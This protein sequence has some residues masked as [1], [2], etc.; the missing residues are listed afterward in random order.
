M[1]KTSILFPLMTLVAFGAFARTSTLPYELI[2]HDPENHL[3]SDREGVIANIDAAMDDWGKW[4]KSKGTIRIRVEVTNDTAASSGRF[5]GTSSTNRF[6]EE[7][8]EFK[9]FEDSSIYKM[10]TGKEVKNSSSEV[11]LYLNPTY[12]REA[13]WID[14]KPELRTTPVPQG[15]VDLVTVFAHELGHGFGINGFLKNSDGA[16][17]ES[18]ALSPFDKFI[19]ETSMLGE[20]NVHFKGPL[21][22]KANDGKDLPI[23][24]VTSDRN[25]TVVHKAETYMC[26]K[27]MSQNLYH[28][29]HFD[30]SS[31]TTD[32]VFFGLMAG[33]WI[34][35]DKKHGQRT[36]V[37]RLDAAILG[38]LGIPLLKSAP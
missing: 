34:V 16:P 38:D 20:N 31:A 36:F 7:W 24:F 1:I 9:A 37:S 33:A 3:G 23:F 22:K 26:G 11:T 25:E 19:V 32:K 15:K 14:P 6:V 27:T 4:I 12:M 2:I 13:Y 10:R 21:T 17:R 18:M 8:K 30:T 29:G 5:G 28:Y 35:R